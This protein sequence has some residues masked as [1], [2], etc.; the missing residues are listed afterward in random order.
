MLDLF[1]VITRDLNVCLIIFFVMHG[2]S[3]L[4]FFDLSVS[5][6]GN[7]PSQNVLILRMLCRVALRTQ[8]VDQRINSA[9]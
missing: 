3:N 7:N 4:S 1:F 9:V 5:G 2:A 6:D 8:T